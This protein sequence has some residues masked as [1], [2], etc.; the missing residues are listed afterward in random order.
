MIN[1]FKKFQEL[2]EREKAVWLKAQQ[3][4][5]LKHWAEAINKAKQ[6]LDVRMHI[7]NQGSIVRLDY[8]EFHMSRIIMNLDSGDLFPVFR[9]LVILQ[10]AT[11]SV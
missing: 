9:F 7:H 10:G 11:I 5:E 8:F 2:R 1:L 6:L 3:R 4:N